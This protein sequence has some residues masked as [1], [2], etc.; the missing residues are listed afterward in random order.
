MKDPEYTLLF[1]DDEADVVEILTDTFE[2]EY[3]VFSATNGEEALAIL[4]RE[5]V[6]LLVTDQRMP[7]MTGIQLIERAHELDPELICII[8]TG[9]TDPP[10]LIDAINRGQVYRYLTKPWELQDL[11]L[12]V[13]AALES[14]ALRRQNASLL[15]EAQSR[16]SAL[17]VLYE[18]SRAAGGGATYREIVDHVTAFLP[19]VVEHV[20]CGTLLRVRPGEQGVLTLRCQAPV[21]E[22][23][24]RRLKDEL[25]QRYEETTTEHLEE[26]DLLVRITGRRTTGAEAPGEDELPGRIF[27]PLR[28]EGRPVGVLGIAAQ[29]P[30]AF[31]AGTERVLDIL[32][33]QI[34]ESIETL[35]QRHD[36]ERQRLKRTIDGMADG[37]IMTDARGEV[38]V[39]NAAARKLLGV[40][41]T[42]TIDTTFLREN[43]GFYP[44]ELVR[45]WERRGERDVS[46]DLVVED[47]V[48]HSVVS[49][50]LDAN[51]ALGGV[52]VALRDVTGARALDRRKQEFVSIIS[53]ELRTP[54]TAITGAIDLLLNG[55]VGEITEKQHRYLSLAKGSSERLNRIVDDLLDLSRF[56]AGKVQLEL[57]VVDLVQVVREAVERYEG[58]V[59]RAKQELH[60]RHP[61][62]AVKVLVDRDRVDQ[63]LNNLLTNAVKFTPEEGGRIEVE[64]FTEQDVASTAGFS[65]WNSGEAIPGEDL[66]RIF[67]QFERSKGARRIRGTGLGLPI[68][69]QLVE[70]HGGSVWAESQ[71]G[72]GAR[73][74]VT[75]P[76]GSLEAAEEKGEREEVTLTG[77][78]RVLVVD[79][80]RGA[81][82]AMK[83]ILLGAGYEV[84]VA[85]HA[86]EALGLARKRRP[87]LMIV[88]VCMPEVDGT[89][90]IEILRHDPET[91]G[92][93]V[94]AVSGKES[95]ERVAKVG[96]AGFLTKPLQPERF[97]G[98]V[99]SLI[100]GI[101][102]GMRVLVVDDD[103]PIRQLCR[104]A[105]EST[106]YLVAEAE[107]ARAAQ[108]QISSFRP[109][110]V[111]LDVMLPDGDGFQFLEALKADRATK[112]TSVIFISAR[113]DTSDKVRALRLGGD[114]YIVKP[115]DAQELVARVDTVLRRRE[116]ELSASPT[117]RLPGGMAIEREVQQRIEA[118]EPYALCYLDIDN[119][120]AFNDYYGYAK[121]DGVILQTGDLLVEAVEHYGSPDDFVGH[122]AG[123]DFVLVTSPERADGI[124]RA[125]LEAFDRII[126]LYYSGKDRQRGF[127]ETQDRYGTERRFPVMTLSVVS[128][129]DPGGR[130][131]DHAEVASR[132]AVLKKQAKTMDGSVYI[133][134]DDTAAETG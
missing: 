60:F 74:V 32:A 21:G 44:F 49:P 15:I 58:A 41:L 9:Y 71:E 113:G 82:Y 42:T 109:D 108:A 118:R 46:E 125:A 48:L 87:A 61:E 6:D 3:R 96:A 26:A 50:L 133:R 22:A 23:V 94:L 102:E 129:I 53:H 57:E 4:E 76:L 59:Q 55:L 104:E 85:H 131:V 110:L 114:D 39:A 52:V 123:D 51:G 130:F 83:G 16:L 78:G 112:L 127:I 120:K 99:A 92:V 45:G 18:V 97:L 17:E 43:L 47:R 14:V 98:V 68:C 116:Q 13:Q 38:Q 24:L 69:R 35:R 62:G 66:E 2:V 132:A 56:A 27:L 36:A 72:Q 107:G 106:G 28:S 31:G 95:G 101:R 67:E 134:D 77:E 105:L 121:A 30:D 75:L 128:V 65:I 10:D 86:E 117:T 70:A 88:D 90:L 93:P 54:L 89:R 100:S 19:R 111:L 84:E 37:L 115:F 5:S 64:V 12:T 73:F 122:I 63:V 126:P 1:V 34:A 20:V 8:L 40:P 79:D 7:R 103:S 33:N 119:L 25:I 80:D 11:T 124:G 81:A 91:R 29:N